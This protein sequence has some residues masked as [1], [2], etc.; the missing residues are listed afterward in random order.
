MEVI[1]R[2]AQESGRRPLLTAVERKLGVTHATFYRNYPDDIEWFR[3]QIPEER[4]PREATPASDDALARLRREN[5]DLRAQ[6]R[7]YAEANRQLAEEHRQ[8][9]EQLEA[10]TNITNLGAH[11]ETNRRNAANPTDGGKP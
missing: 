7:I 5:A 4:P 9:T 1:L 10:A 6:V 2:E 3:A 11:R 8:L